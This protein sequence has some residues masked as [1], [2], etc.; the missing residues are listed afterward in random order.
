MER[1]KQLN[2]VTNKDLIFK[3]DVKSRLMLLNEALEKYFKEEG[4]LFV[5]DPTRRV[6]IH[7]NKEGKQMIEDAFQRE[8]AKWTED[9]TK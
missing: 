7:T 1:L 5:K 8:Y 2:M 3:P 9:S 4:S 6:I